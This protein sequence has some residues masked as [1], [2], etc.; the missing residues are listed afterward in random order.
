MIIEKDAFGGKLNGINLIENYSGFVDGIVGPQLAAEMLGQAMKYGVEIEQADVTGIASHI[1][2]RTVN[3]SDGQKF[4][5]GVVIIA[6]GSR[7]RNMGVPG[8]DTF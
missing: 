2:S 4:T 8:E 5:C 7:S 1:H 6:G 3:C